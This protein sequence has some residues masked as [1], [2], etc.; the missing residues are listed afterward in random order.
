MT[1][2]FSRTTCGQFSR[3]TCGQF[4]RTTCGHLG[5]LLNTSEPGSDFDGDT[6]GRDIDD[7]SEGA[8]VGTRCGDLM[9]AHNMSG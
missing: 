1:G 8:I 9:V 5:C 2:Q 7:T 4:S 3:T 6:V